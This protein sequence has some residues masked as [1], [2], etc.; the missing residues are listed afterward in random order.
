MQHRYFEFYGLQLLKKAKLP[1]GDTERHI[2]LN[3]AAVKELKIDNPIGKTLSRKDQ[4]GFIIDGIFK[5]FYIAPPTVPVKPGYARVQSGK[6][7]YTE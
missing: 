7:E 3:E 6:K 5:D 4:K 1:E 2:L